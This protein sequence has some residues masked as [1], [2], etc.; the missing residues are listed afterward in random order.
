MAVVDKTRLITGY[1]S[2]ISI[3]YISPVDSFYSYVFIGAKEKFV[4]KEISIESTI[5]S[6][7]TEPHSRTIRILRRRKNEMNDS[8]LVHA[9][10]YQLHRTKMPRLPRNRVPRI[11]IRPNL[12][13]PFLFSRHP[14]DVSLP[15]VAIL[16]H[17]PTIYRDS[18]N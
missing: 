15:L 17:P 11:D 18:V 7:E 12:F 3:N 13:N 14:F 8:T 9:I 4:S 1:V 16:V 2:R 10:F 5:P 6:E